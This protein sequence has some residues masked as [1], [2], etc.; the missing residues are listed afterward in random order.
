MQ[1]ARNEKRETTLRIELLTLDDGFN[2]QV[3][4]CDSER[5]QQRDVWCA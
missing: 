2:A 3:A 4:R 5:A 1:H